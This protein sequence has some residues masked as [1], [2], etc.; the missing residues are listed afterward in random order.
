MHR[1]YFNAIISCKSLTWRLRAPSRPHWLAYTIYSP[2]QYYAGESARVAPSVALHRGFL[3]S[4]PDELASWVR[5]SWQ[6]GLQCEGGVNQRVVRNGISP[7]T[8][9]VSACGWSGC[10]SLFTF[11]SKFSQSTMFADTVSA[12]LLPRCF[13]GRLGRLHVP[14]VQATEPPLLSRAQILAS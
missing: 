5:T 1:H 8:V 2:Y 13:S 6:G 12:F 11:A 3:A 4:A 9:P 10:V 14:L 7:E